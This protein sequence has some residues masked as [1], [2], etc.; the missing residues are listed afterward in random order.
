VSIG[1][2]AVDMFGRWLFPMNQWQSR[3]SDMR[4]QATGA[5]VPYTIAVA[6]Q[7]LSAAPAV[8]D[9]LVPHVR[10]GSMAVY[11]LSVRG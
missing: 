5:T 9:T 3:H 1:T 11:N 7:S 10:S 6:P 2:A 8:R 4:L